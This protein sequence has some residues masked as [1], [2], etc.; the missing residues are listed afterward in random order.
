MAKKL[1]GN[2]QWLLKECYQAGRMALFRV[3]RENEDSIPD[4]CSFWEFAREEVERSLKEVIK[5]ARRRAAQR[6]ITEKII[7]AMH[8]E[9]GKTV[10]PF[11][12]EE[13]R[14]AVGQLCTSPDALPEIDRAILQRRYCIGQSTELPQSCRSIG[15]EFGLEPQQS[16]DIAK[17]IPH[18]I[19]MALLRERERTDIPAAARSMFPSLDAWLILNQAERAKLHIANR[20]LGYIGTLFDIPGNP[21]SQRKAFLLLTRALFGPDSFATTEKELRQMEAKATAE[22]T[23][24]DDPE[25]WRSAIRAEI[26]DH[27][28]WCRLP[29]A[30]RQTL[31]I[32][33]KGLVAL[34]RTFGLEGN[35]LNNKTVFHRLGTLVYGEVPQNH[36]MLT[37]KR[38]EIADRIRTALHRMLGP[39]AP[40]SRTLRL[41][42]GSGPDLDTEQAIFFALANADMLSDREARILRE[43]Y[44]RPGQRSLRSIAKELGISSNYVSRLR[45]QAVDKLSRL[46]AETFDIELIQ[47]A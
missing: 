2:R 40:R 39:D 11:G 8:E 32:H 6:A 46:L 47:V 42:H 15:E 16:A 23:L 22:T 24:G 1:A 37:D 45:D 25:R 28:S 3:L 5:D 27:R 19:G 14:D 13:I 12:A 34:A 43:G 31:K 18:R 44:L 41:L 9:I 7:S 26:P 21:I 36:L 4:D 29:N 38:Y 33:G 10:A 35:P 30:T 20:G 17:K